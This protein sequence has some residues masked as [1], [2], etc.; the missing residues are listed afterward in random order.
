MTEP[1]KPLLEQLTG[2][3]G[4]VAGLLTAVAALIVAWTHW[5]GDGGSA[6]VV[7]P[8]NNTVMVEPDPNPDP[9]DDGNET[10][11][12]TG[13]T[14]DHRCRAILGNPQMAIIIL[15]A[16]PSSTSAQVGEIH[17]NEVVYAGDEVNGWRPARTRSGVTGWTRAGNLSV[18]CD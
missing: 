4:A 13:P 8:A 16:E 3:V 2:T 10:A 12:A 7:D 6:P 15:R 11:A 9:K 18:V 14:T 17:P 5:G 1:R